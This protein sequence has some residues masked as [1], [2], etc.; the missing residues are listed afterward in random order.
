MESGF[1]IWEETFPM[2]HCA[3]AEMGP[4]GQSLKDHGRA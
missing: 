1:K 4:S 3:L 2:E